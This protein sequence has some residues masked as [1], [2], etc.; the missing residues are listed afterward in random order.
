MMT[1]KFVNILKKENVTA[2]KNKLCLL[3]LF[4]D[5][6]LFWCLQESQSHMNSAVMYTKL[7]ISE[8]A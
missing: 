4:D 7:M 2:F 8:R 6:C 3:V 1:R 5:E